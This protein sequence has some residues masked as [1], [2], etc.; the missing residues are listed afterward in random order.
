MI[1]SNT[2]RSARFAAL[3]FVAA[4]ALIGSASQA[5]VELKTYEDA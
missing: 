1:A 4:G 3:G 5:Q 2:F